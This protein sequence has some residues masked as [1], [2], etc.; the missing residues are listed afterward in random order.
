MV[1]KLQASKG[2]S[3]ASARRAPLLEPRLTVNCAY[4]LD[5][6]KAASA[7]ASSASTTAHC[8]KAV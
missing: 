2:Q 7:T 1:W 4:L 5:G 3:S 6:N 8:C